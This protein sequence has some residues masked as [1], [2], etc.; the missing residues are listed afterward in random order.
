MVPT[1]AQ[2]ARMIDHSILHPTFTDK[3][4]ITNCEIAV[5]YQVAT[6]CIKPYHTA[7]AYELVKNSGVGVCSV[8]CFPHGNGSTSIK[9]AEALE[10]IQNGANE[11]D[12]VVNVGKVLG[13]NWTFVAE[14]IRE[15]NDACVSNG[16]ILKV[17]FENDFLPGDFEKIKLCEICSE[18]GVA[19]VKTSSGY[20]FVKKENGDYNYDGAT[21]HDIALMR[22]HCRPE[23]QI[24]AAGGIRNLDQ[25]LEA[26]ELGASRVGATATPQLL[27]EALRRGF[28]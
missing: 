3:D 13:H 24:K 2:I 17:I 4:L 15:V 19:F 21:A 6:V 26:W 5:K 7:D 20:G 11:L 22:K 27:A 23:V 10:V 1:L 8:I 28:V 14:D 25:L 16:A 9:V 18:I 12:M